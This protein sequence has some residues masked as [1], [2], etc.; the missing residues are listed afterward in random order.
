M[1]ATIVGMASR[2]RIACIAATIAA[3]ASAS[4]SFSMRAMSGSTAWRLLM[5]PSACAAVTRIRTSSESSCATRSGT[6]WPPMPRR[7][8]EA[9]PR[10]SS[11]ASAS[12]R[13]R[14]ASPRWPPLITVGSRRATSALTA[15]PNTATRRASSRSASTVG[16]TDSR[17]VC[18]PPSAS[19]SAPGTTA[20]PNATS[21]ACARVT[22]YALSSPRRSSKTGMASATRSGCELSLCA[23]W[24]MASARA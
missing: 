5:A 21:A 23:N 7:A 4:R 16:M 10:R 19:V 20:E 18:H 15:C 22:T 1:I 12:S 8:V 14:S 6:A 17:T 3:R 9:L 24:S 13:M 11:S 2:A